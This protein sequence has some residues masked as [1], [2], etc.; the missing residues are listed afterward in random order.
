[1]N[2]YLLEQDEN[3][4]YDTYDSC[5]ISARSDTDA[6]KIH[7]SPWIR[8]DDVWAYSD[9]WASS[10]ENVRVTLIGTAVDSEFSGVILSSFNAG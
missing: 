7:P 8:A 9:G 4:G 5:V 1:M 2:L 6:R 10:P 3:R